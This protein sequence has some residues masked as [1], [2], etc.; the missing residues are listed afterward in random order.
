[1]EF[2]AGAA[3]TAAI[4]RLIATANRAVL[5]VTP[6]FHPT[7]D[8]FRAL[9]AARLRG[10]G[11]KIWMRDDN[12][13]GDWQT[14]V[15]ECS[16]MN[17]KVEAVPRLHAKLYAS[18]SM[19]IL[20]SRNLYAASINSW[21]AAVVVEK[22]ANPEGYEAGIQ[23][24]RDLESYIEGLE[25]THSADELE[26]F[27]LTRSAEGLQ[28]LRAAAE[29]GNPKAMRYHEFC[30]SC[31]TS[32]FRDE[33]SDPQCP[34]CV[35]TEHVEGTKLDF[36]HC[37]RCGVDELRQRGRPWC[38]GCYR[39]L[40]QR[41]GR[42]VE[43]ALRDAAIAKPPPSAEFPNQG[44]KWSGSDEAQLRALWATDTPTVQIAHQFG[45]TR[46]AIIARAVKL[47]LAPDSETAA[48][49]P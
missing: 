31:G 11:V 1:M 5:V 30:V 4:D 45:R 9:A 7:A 15:E 14:V 21:D 10:V 2:I 44:Q 36:K 41:P 46:R 47:G 39:Q 3:V 48:R 40:N 49:R 24:L 37:N 20:T 12:K 17:I 33:E 22:A 25:P 29:N 13:P 19:V 18:E 23:L 43:F 42:R 38:R 34:R 28:K 16:R 27:L 32:R 26:M 8:Q 35:A 6:F